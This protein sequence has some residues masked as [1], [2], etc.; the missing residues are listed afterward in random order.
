MHKKTALALGAML[1]LQTLFMLVIES[2]FAQAEDGEQKIT[3]F[4]FNFYYS[5]GRSQ[6]ECFGNCMS[7]CQSACYATGGPKV[8]SCSCGGACA[9]CSGVFA[10]CGGQI[11]CQKSLPPQY[12][13]AETGTTATEDALPMIS[14]EGGVPLGGAGITPGETEE[15]I[16]A[17]QQEAAAQYFN[18]WEQYCASAPNCDSC[19]YRDRCIWTGAGCTSCQAPTC[20]FSCPNGKRAETQQ[21]PTL[22]KAREAAQTQE[23]PQPT[24]IQ[25]GA[26]PAPTF[27]PT[28][29][30]PEP[31]PTPTPPV[32]CRVY[33]TCEACSSATP[34]TEGNCAW[35]EFTNLC[36][37]IAEMAQMDQFD[38]KT[39][40]ISDK[41]SCKKEKEPE[42]DCF[43]LYDCFSCTGVG[44][45]KRQCQWSD[46]AGRC[47]KY[48]EGSS[49]KT[50]QKEGDYIVFPGLC[51]KH[52]CADYSECEECAQ[53]SRCAWS[54]QQGTC[55]QYQGISSGIIYPAW[56]QKNEKAKLPDTCPALC[57][58]DEQGAITECTYPSAAKP[59]NIVSSKNAA[60]NAWAASGMEE[61]KTVSLYQEKDN[62]FAYVVRGTR[63]GVLFA[64]LPVPI[65]YEVIVNATTGKIEKVNKPWWEILTT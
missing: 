15:Q 37:S 24:P 28:P 51:Q 19:I 29:V 33:K 50:A 8:I 60:L 46:R 65:D 63:T 11:I 13:P 56:C 42:T 52:D 61:L 48:E 34:A 23:P 7:S 58:C 64:L 62:E 20:R 55:L 53:N 25:P 10:G 45:V 35:S 54:P 5:Y 1:A 40:W 31:T 47:V 32:N 4:T 44:G 16:Q 59:E 14:G 9:A 39:G 57:K 22:E 17:Q 21:P 12:S 27:E 18:Q 43:K 6:G 38:L 49:F 3:Q 41:D 36:V 26:T 30:P 2:P